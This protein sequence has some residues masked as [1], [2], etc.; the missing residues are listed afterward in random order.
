LKRAA[1]FKWMS[2][3]FMLVAVLLLMRTLPIRSMQQ[4]LTDR[5]EELGAVGPIVFTLLYV[6]ATVLL[7]PGS[8]LT[9]AG[10]AV[11]GLAVAFVT[12]SIGSVT[13][14]ALAF[15][16]ARYLARER[17]EELVRS[18]PKFAAIDRA[19]SQGGWRIVALLR[20][21]PVVP[22]NVQ[23]YLYGLTDIN[24][25]P[26]VIASA[27]AM[28]PGTFLYVYLGHI[29]GVAASGPRERSTAEWIMLTIGLIATV[30]VTAYITWL[31]KKTLKQITMLGGDG[32]E[33][34]DRR[35]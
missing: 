8:V 10:G 25:W 31:A 22:F 1:L 6:V 13:G 30:A 14:A 35:E 16:I 21:S 4:S 32:G 9:L 5:I 3:G 34:P 15:L 11:F 12:V 17:I 7:I 27:V 29:A 23:N 33:L 24:F 26:Y 18:R 28:A 19:V 20:L 2:L